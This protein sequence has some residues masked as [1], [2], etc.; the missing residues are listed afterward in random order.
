MHWDWALELSPLQKYQPFQR[1]T[2]PVFQ[3]PK[4]GQVFNHMRTGLLRRLQQQPVPSLPVELCFLLVQLK[5][6]LRVQKYRR[7]KLLPANEQKRVCEGVSGRLLW[8]PGEVGMCRV[9]LLQ[10]RGGTAF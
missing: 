4:G 8:G 6:L 3:T 7:G 5:L 9:H 1:Y 2:C 10:L